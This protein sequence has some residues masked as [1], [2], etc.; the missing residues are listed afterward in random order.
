MSVPH[1][2]PAPLSVARPRRFA[3]EQLE[4][5]IAPAMAGMV[6][7]H[8]HHHHATTPF[9]GFQFQ[10]QSQSQSQ[11]QFQSLSFSFSFS[12]TNGTAMSSAV[13]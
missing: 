9:F 4:D 3:I 6:P 13:L 5:R 1:A 7:S 2:E 11:F 12:V 8:H 10:S